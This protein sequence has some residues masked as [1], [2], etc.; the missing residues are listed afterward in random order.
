M[1]IVNIELTHAEYQQLKRMLHRRYPLSAITSFEQHMVMALSEVA[2]LEGR[3]VPP[4]AP[5][6]AA[7]RKAR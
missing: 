6:K 3:L 2:G 1:P 7:N 5:G 4:Y